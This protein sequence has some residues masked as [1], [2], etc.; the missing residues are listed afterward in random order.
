MQGTVR[1]ILALGWISK[2]PKYIFS[3]TGT[4][5]IVAPQQANRSRVE[6]F[7][8]APVTAR[9][10]KKTDRV[11]VVKLLCDVFSAFDAHDHYRQGTLNIEEYWKATLGDIDY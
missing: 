7:D 4:T 9:Y 1:K 2:V 6:I 11:H 3:T 10:K 8:G 5:N